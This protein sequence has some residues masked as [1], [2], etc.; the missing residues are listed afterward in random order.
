MAGALNPYIDPGK[1]WES[2]KAQ[3]R[4]QAIAQSRDKR[5]GHQQA[6]DRMGD[7]VGGSYDAF[8]DL[9]GTKPAG[10]KLSEGDYLGAASD[11]AYGLGLELPFAMAAGPASMAKKPF[12]RML[13]EFA[14][15]M[16]GKS[17]GEEGLR[18]LWKIIGPGV[19]K[20]ASAIPAG[21]AAV[22]VLSQR[23]DSIGEDERYNDYY[24]ID[25]DKDYRSG[26]SELLEAEGLSPGAE[27][28]RRY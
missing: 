21:A 16:G 7:F 12:T 27:L 19:K 23:S 8:S 28:M 14:N 26:M 4:K 2:I 5:P 22:G 6:Y 10:L 9:I 13:M 18:E 24:D 25:M 11:L 20:T 17:I 15:P 3:N 1:I